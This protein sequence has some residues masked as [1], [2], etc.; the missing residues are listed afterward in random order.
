MNEQN[1][2]EFFPPPDC[3]NVTDEGLLKISALSKIEELHIDGM[4]ING[5]GL[6]KFHTLKY[7]NCAQSTVFDQGLCHILSQCH[8]LQKLEIQDCDNVSVSTIKTA[9]KIATAREEKRLEIIADSR[10]LIDQVHKVEKIPNTLKLWSVDC[11]KDIDCLSLDFYT[12]K[13]VK[14]ENH[15][16]KRFDVELAN[17]NSTEVAELNDDCFNNVINYLPITI[18][19][20]LERGRDMIHLIQI[21]FIQVPR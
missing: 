17:T 15:S 19:I 5:E 7:L 1:D 13:F 8:D 21:N 11:Y 14:G 9:I 2:I 4:P 6:M 18:R 12:P 10:L 20:K 3:M 16:L